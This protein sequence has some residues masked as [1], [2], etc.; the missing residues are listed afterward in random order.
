MIGILTFCTIFTLLAAGGLL[1]FN[2]KRRPRLSSILDNPSHLLSLPLQRAGASLGTFVSLFGR[3]VPRTHKEV[4]L[5]RRKLVRA[6]FRENFALQ[7]FYGAKFLSMVI[8][9]FLVLATGV[10]SLNYFIVIVGA[11]GAGF[12]A[13]DFWL[14]RQVKQRQREIR[15][16]LPDVLDLLVVCVEA[17][18]SLDQAFLRAAHEMGGTRSALSDELSVVRLEQRAGSSRSESWRRFA[19]RT[20]V[21]SIR[22]LVSMLNQSE[23]FGTSIARGLRVHA[24]GLR[25]QRIQ[26][27][28]EQAAKTGIK[29]VFPLVLFIFPNLFLVVLGPALME[30][31]DSLR[32]TFHH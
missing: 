9:L 12:L 32:G 3:V 15:L 31:L 4:S 2:R 28:E 22:H 5:L 14:T 11:L 30:I 1:V 21:E 27:I 17:G 16:Q 23:Q 26:Q 10:A 13:P 6:G 24:Q 25:T 20:G 19:E 7:T 18:L 8:L 29:I